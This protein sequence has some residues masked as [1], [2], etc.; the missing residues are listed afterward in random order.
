MKKEE[1]L[2]S[3][4]AGL[5]DPLVAEYNK[6]LKNYR[7]SRWEPAELDGGRLSEI[8]FSILRGHVDGVFAAKPQKP[9]NMVDACKDFEK[10][11]QAKF[12]RSVRIQIPR[13]LISLYEI[14]NNRGV[15]HV[16]GDVDSN[17]MDSEA[18]LALSKW[19]LAELVRIFH[20]VTT[21]VASDAVEMIAE[22]SI[23]VVWAVAESRRVLDPNLKKWEQVLLLLYSCSSGAKDDDLCTWVEYTNV[24]LFKTRVLAELHKKRLLEHNKKSGVV[25]I[26][27]TGVKYV[28]EKLS[29]NLRD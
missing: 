9:P 15:G 14:R 27:P 19:L 26:S 18:V 21:E 29:L 12:A 13:V 25:T 24:S 4:P 6:I 8:V 20:G 5:R 3:V 17:R 7:E 28:E 11:D 23:P 16:G 10:A 2:K 22:R 1:I